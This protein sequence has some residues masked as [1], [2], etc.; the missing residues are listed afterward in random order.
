MRDWIEAAIGAVM[1]FVMA[2]LI[3]YALPLVALLME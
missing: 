3:W 1:L 2:I